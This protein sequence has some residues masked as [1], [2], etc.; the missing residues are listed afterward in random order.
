MLSLY[1]FSVYIYTLS[2]RLLTSMAPGNSTLPLHVCD[3][4]DTF[5]LRRTSCT[6]ANILLVRCNNTYDGKC[7][8]V[9]FRNAL[10]APSNNSAYT[11]VCTACM[12]TLASM[13]LLFLFLLY[14]FCLYI[15]SG[16]SI[17]R[18]SSFTS[19]TVAFTSSDA[20]CICCCCFTLCKWHS[21]HIFF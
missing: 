13:L 17:K 11:V 1:Y 16:L 9:H 15:V 4:L 5:V 20:N 7:T 3:I 8:S 18:T 12:S 6:P 21:L 2:Q 14:K 19:C 10:C